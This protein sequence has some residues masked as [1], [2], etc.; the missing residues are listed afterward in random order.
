MKL[1]WD[2]TAWDDDVR[3]QTQSGAVLQGTP[4]FRGIFSHIG[5]YVLELVYYR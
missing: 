4:P 2:E 3:W 1:G 5:T